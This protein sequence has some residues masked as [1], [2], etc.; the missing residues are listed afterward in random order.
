MRVSLIQG[1]Y[2]LFT[3]IDWYCG[4]PLM[5]GGFLEVATIAWVYGQY[6]AR[7]LYHACIK[8]RFSL[9]IQ[10]VG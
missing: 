3:L 1:G 2:Y 10:F 6:W 8:I 7:N 9:D 4:L 5:L